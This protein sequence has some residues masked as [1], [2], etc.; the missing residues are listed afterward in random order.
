MSQPQPRTSLPL[1]PLADCHRSS[2]SDGAARPSP[3]RHIYIRRGSRRR[4]AS[5]EEETEGGKYISFFRAPKMRGFALLMSSRCVRA[6]TYSL[7]HTHTHNGI[8]GMVTIPLMR[9]FFPRLPAAVGVIMRMR[10][11]LDIKKLHRSVWPVSPLAFP[12]GDLRDS[13]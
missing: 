8:D 3:S 12:P 9:L 5:E 7:T 13:P 10:H 6:R 2:R 4:G 1:T 11:L